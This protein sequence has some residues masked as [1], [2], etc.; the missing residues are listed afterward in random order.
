MKMCYCYD[1]LQNQL[2]KHNPRLYYVLVEFLGSVMIPVPQRE[3]ILDDS[4]FHP[5]NFY[6]I[7]VTI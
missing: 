7:D 1:H 6:K 5:P 4:W 2:N 3:A